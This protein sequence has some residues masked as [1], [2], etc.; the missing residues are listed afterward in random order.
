[1]DMSFWRQQKAREP[2]FPDIEWSKPEQK[3]QAGRLAIIGGNKLGFAGVAESYSVAYESGIGAVRVLLPDALK[4][5]IP[6]AWTDVALA[7]ST[8]SGGFSKDAATHLLALADWGTMTLLIGDAGRNSETAIV[9]E[10]LIRN[11]IGPIVLT[12]D[13]I[14]LIKNSADTLVNRPDT[15]LVLSFAQLQKLF[16]SVYYPKVLTFSMQLLQLVDAVHKFTITYPITLAVLHKDTLVVAHGGHVTT[17]PWESPMAI[18]RGTTAT[19]AAV[20]W[21]WN[22]KQPL[23]AITASLLADNAKD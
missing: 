21:T 17:T 1:M 20:Y 9:Y 6:V 14:D 22:P 18:W 2:L 23:E 19:R 16:Q 15:L 8:V 13:A 11:H 3:S 4:K 5:Q 12:R 7:P 10:S